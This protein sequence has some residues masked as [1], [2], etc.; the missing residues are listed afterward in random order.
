MNNALQVWLATGGDLGGSLRI[1]ASFCGVVGI[2]PSVGRVTQSFTAFTALKAVSGPMARNVGDLALLL[3]AMTGQHPR[4]RRREESRRKKA[5]K[6][7][8][9]VI[10]SLLA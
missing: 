7:K 3:D 1:P 9:V 6:R 8:I 4:Y 10:I 2:R 5:E